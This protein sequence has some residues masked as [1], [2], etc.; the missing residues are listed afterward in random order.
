METLQELMKKLL[1]DTFAMYLK[2]HNYHWNVEG[3]YFIQL[4]DF[5]GKLYLE[6][7]AAVDPMAEEIRAMDTY[8]PGSF[9]RFGELTEVQDELSVPSAM[10]MVS[11]LEADNQKVLKTLDLAFK[12]A[13][14]FDKQG[15]ADFL[16]A[17]IDIHNK[18]SWM[19]KAIIKK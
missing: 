19:L 4:H 8:V 10:E 3:P 18:H 11:R 16:S 1:A 12:L 15:L 14:K 2:A 6:L 17:R 5:F 13:N 7:H 9:K